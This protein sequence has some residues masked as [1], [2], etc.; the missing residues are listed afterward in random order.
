MSTHPPTAVEGTE[1]R[2]DDRDIRALTE[3]HTV[4]EDIGLVRG[5][6]DLYLVISQSGNEYL[7]DSRDEP[8]E[9]PDAL[10]RVLGGCRSLVLPCTR[11]E[12][13]LYAIDRRSRPRLRR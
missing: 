8:C 6:D 4:V 13:L 12:D 1:N 2:T 10:Y 3:H 9:C 5:A 7:V 11:V